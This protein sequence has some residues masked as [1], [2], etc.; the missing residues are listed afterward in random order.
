MTPEAI[1]RVNLRLGSGGAIVCDVPIKGAGEL[2]GDTAIYYDGKYLLCESVSPTGAAMI[3][4]GIHAL[5]DSEVL[6]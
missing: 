5:P 2:E 4:K 6:L 1:K 3:I